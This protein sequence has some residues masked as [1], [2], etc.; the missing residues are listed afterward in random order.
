[1]RSLP[2]L[3][4]TAS[5]RLVLVSPS[6]RRI[7]Y[8]RRGG[9]ETRSSGFGAPSPCFKLILARPVE[10]SV[11]TAFAVSTNKNLVVSFAPLATAIEHRPRH[12]AHQ[13]GGDF[14]VLFICLYRLL[15]LRGWPLSYFFVPFF[16]F[17]L[18]PNFHKNPERASQAIPTPVAPIQ[19]SQP[20]RFNPERASQA[21]PTFASILT[22]G[23]LRLFQSRTGFTGHPD[24][25]LL[26]AFT[27]TC[28]VSI[29]NGLHRPSRRFHQYG[30]IASERLQITVG[31]SVSIPNGLH[32]PSRP[33][34]LE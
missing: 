4:M 32:R 12:A 27:L 24:F 28:A 19:Q 9:S 29:P 18:F 6:E 10:L 14:L 30:R 22:L 26:G 16:L 25:G 2:L 1:M 15:A 34:R 7:G 3:G 5:T 13:N 11:T 17:T 8:T 23:A 33:T 20:Q 21:I 31:T